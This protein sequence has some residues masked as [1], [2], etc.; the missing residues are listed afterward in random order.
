MKICDKS[1]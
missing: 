1:V